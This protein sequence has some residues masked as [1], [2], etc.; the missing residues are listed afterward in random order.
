[1]Y[2]EQIK[3]K[4]KTL[5]M[6]QLSHSLYLCMTLC[7]DS[8]IDDISYI[9]SEPGNA[10]LCKNAVSSLGKNLDLYGFYL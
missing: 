8:K 2:K 3:I 1:M 4:T 6:L 10:V 5:I 9:N 7:D